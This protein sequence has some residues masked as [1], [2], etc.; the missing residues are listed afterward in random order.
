LQV[1]AR[2]NA[3]RSHQRPNKIAAIDVAHPYSLAELVDIAEQNNPTTLSTLQP[4]AR[5]SVYAE[6]LMSRYRDLHSLLTTFT[7]MFDHPIESRIDIA[8]PPFL[9][10]KP[11]D[12]SLRED[13]R[14]H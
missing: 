1:P 3:L 14:N 9:Q 7:R 10:Q 13:E 6:T 11:S 2:R 5:E 12:V 4:D 8:S